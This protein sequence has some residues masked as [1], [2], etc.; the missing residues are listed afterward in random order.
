MDHDV[1]LESI[2]E[3]GANTANIKIILKIVQEIKLDI[4]KDREFNA[5]KF[6]LLENVMKSIH[7]ELGSKASLTMYQEHRDALEKQNERIKSLEIIFSKRKKL[8]DNALTSVNWFLSQFRNIAFVVFIAIVTI[9]IIE[10]H[11]PYAIKWIA[12]KISV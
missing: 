11:R 12:E 2:K 8:I 10:N 3:L 5:K 7:R 4:I 6:E 1:D 9:D